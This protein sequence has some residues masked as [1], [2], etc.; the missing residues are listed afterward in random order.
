MVFCL[1]KAQTTV[2]SINIVN[3]NMISECTISDLEDINGIGPIRAR[4][5]KEAEAST[6]RELE[7][8]EGIG[9][10]TIKILK[11]NMTIK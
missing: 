5:I 9:K 8:V 3:I 10:A 1:F 2:Y 11:K 4:L 6:W 7:E